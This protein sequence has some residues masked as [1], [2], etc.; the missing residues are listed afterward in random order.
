MAPDPEP[1]AAPAQPGQSAQTP[2]G[3]PGPPRPLRPE[4]E[5]IFGTLIHLSGLLWLLSFPGIVGVLLIW[6]LKRDQSAF[7]D[8]HGKE[9]LNFQISF[10][11]YGIGLTALAIVGFVLTFVIVGIFLF[12]PAVVAS[13]GLIVLQV[14]TAIL[15]AIEA[16][17][18]GYYRYPLTLRFIH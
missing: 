9:A 5:R 13:I 11:I 15:G 14:V 18:G 12:I 16:N 17:R 10:L 8:A 6:L 1:T 7:V 4:E 2:P 3:P